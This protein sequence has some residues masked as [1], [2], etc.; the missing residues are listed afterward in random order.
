VFDAVDEV[1]DAVDRAEV[2][3]QAAIFG[4]TSEVVGRMVDHLA[5]MVCR[6]NLDTQCRRGPDVLPFAGRKDS[7]M[8]TLSI[9]DALRTFSIRSLVAAR[10]ADAGRIEALGEHSQFLAPPGR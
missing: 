7:A 1:L 9:V 4:G 10:E 6:V 5:N 3:Q 2:G 8:G